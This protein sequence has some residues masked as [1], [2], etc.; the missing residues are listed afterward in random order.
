MRYIL[1]ALLLMIVGAGIFVARSGE[2]ETQTAS[3]TSTSTTAPTSTQATAT[4]PTT[5]TLDQASTAE[6][7]DE[8][9]TGNNNQS[10]A[11][12]SEPASSGQYTDYYDGAI[13]ATSGNKIL[14]FHADWCPQCRRLEN[15]ILSST[16]PADTTI[17]KVDYD[18]ESALK[19]KYGVRNQTTTVLVGDNGELLKTYGAYANPSFDAVISNLL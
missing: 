18:E 2:D 1:I 10:D 9:D 5:E 15:D 4:E 12:N 13:S 11:A 6:E 7:T 19:D 3:R 8:T 14:F 16:I 17:F